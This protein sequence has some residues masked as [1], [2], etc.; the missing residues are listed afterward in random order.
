MPF[1]ALSVISAPY[2]MTFPNLATK[3]VR[4]DVCLSLKSACFLVN[5]RLAHTADDDQALIVK[6]PRAPVYR[7]RENQ[8]G[9][10]TIKSVDDLD[11]F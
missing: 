10:M 7:R 9:F 5:Q 2:Q 4:Q 11:F 6:E 3:D 8:L 1:F